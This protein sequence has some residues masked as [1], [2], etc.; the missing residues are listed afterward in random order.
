MYGDIAS[1]S[2]F[3]TFD[4]DTL[5]ARDG[6]RDVVDCGA[7]ADTAQVDQLDVVAFCSVV[8][9][10]AVAPPGGGGPLA[11]ASFAG[12]KKTVKVNRR[13]RFSYGFRAGAGLKGKAVFRNVAKKSFTTPAGGRVTLK[14]ALTRRKLALLRRTGRIKTKLTVTL[15]DGAGGSSV[16]SK[17]V[18]LKR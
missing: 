11:K 2:V 10:E 4:P 3:C 16:A 12:S 8:D 14:M 1:C 5:L 6:E 9:R 18:T 13:G 17:R 7:G 15:R